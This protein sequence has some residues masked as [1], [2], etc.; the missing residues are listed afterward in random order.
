MYKLITCNIL[1]LCI[2]Q[3]KDKTGEGSKHD[4]KKQVSFVEQPFVTNEYNLHTLKPKIFARRMSVSPDQLLRRQPILLPDRDVTVEKKQLNIQDADETE[5]RNTI[6]RPVISPSKQ[7]Q[8][9]SPIFD[10][11]QSP[12]SN[13]HKEKGGH[14]S[15]EQRPSST[16][17]DQKFGY[18]KAGIAKR[19]SI[20]PEPVKLNSL[21]REYCRRKRTQSARK[22]SIKTSQPENRMVVR[23]CLMKV[24]EKR[25]KEEPKISEESKLYIQTEAYTDRWEHKRILDGEARKL[26]KEAFKQMEAAKQ[27]RKNSVLKKVGTLNMNKWKGRKK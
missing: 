23:H 2:K 8:L 26:E 27:R 17:N 22:H 14:T 16:T 10:R 5:K 9:F 25:I 13:K 24:P 7:R 20:T 6:L 18:M 19:Q 15:P 12:L 3:K 1:I 11:C 21:G 4:V